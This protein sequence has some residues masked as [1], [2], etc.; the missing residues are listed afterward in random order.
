MPA[1][2]QRGEAE[3]IT[4][5]LTK[6]SGARVWHSTRRHIEDMLSMRVLALAACDDGTT[7][8]VDAAHEG[9]PK[10]KD[11]EP[12]PQKQL[13]NFPQG[14]CYHQRV[15]LSGLFVASLTKSRSL[16]KI[17]KI[18]DTETCSQTEF[19]SLLVTEY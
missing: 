11:S 10:P 17:V 9:N 14:P 6:L 19:F 16:C 4:T 8:T 2:Q 7:R 15:P 13:K 3:R 5:A 1:R 12:H 18:K